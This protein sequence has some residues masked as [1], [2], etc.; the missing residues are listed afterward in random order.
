MIEIYAPKQLLFQFL[1]LYS[2]GKIMIRM[3]ELTQLSIL[4]IVFETPRGREEEV[5]N[6]D[7][8]NSYYCIPE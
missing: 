3:D 6:A 7:A 2:K 5:A 1:L 8:F 4:I